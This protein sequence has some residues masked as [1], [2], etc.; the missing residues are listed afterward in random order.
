MKYARN[1]TIVFACLLAAVALTPV[2]EAGPSPSAGNC[3]C[4]CPSNYWCYAAGCGGWQMCDD[5][6]FNHCWGGEGFATSTPVS[7][8]QTLEGF[9]SS[10]QAETPDSEK[11]S[12]QS[13]D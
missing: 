5:F 8:T 3:Y 7:E 10:L 11:P 4:D 6:T 2:T 1:L 9:L 13:A 12:T